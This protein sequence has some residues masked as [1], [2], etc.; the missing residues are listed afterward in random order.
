[1][2]GQGGQCDQ[3]MLVEEVESDSPVLDVLQI[4]KTAD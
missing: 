3:D 1:M 4:K 2:G